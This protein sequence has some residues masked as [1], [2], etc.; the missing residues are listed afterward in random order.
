[1]ERTPI[2]FF[3]TAIRLSWYVGLRHSQEEI[4]VNIG[5]IR[6]NMGSVN[7]EGKIVNFN[8]WMIAIDDK[9]GQTFVRYNRGGR[10]REEWQKMLEQIKIG[11][12]VSIQGCYSVNYSGIIQLKLTPTGRITLLQL[13]DMER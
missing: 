11:N 7:I 6:N 9:S 13:E 2:G 10:T 1:V 8:R 3:S 12:L 4:L 5:D